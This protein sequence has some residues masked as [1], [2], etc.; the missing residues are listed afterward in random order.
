M[1]TIVCGNDIHY[2]VED[3]FSLP[4]TAED[5]F[6]AGDSLRFDIADNE[7]NEPLISKSFPL[8]DGV[9]NITLSKEERAGLKIGDYIYRIIIIG[10]AG[11][12]V[13]EKSG[14]FIVKWGV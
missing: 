1:I 14:A 13:T 6:S 9:F 2:S 12:T 5:G 7:N 4:V 3:S 11:G 8:S 10:A